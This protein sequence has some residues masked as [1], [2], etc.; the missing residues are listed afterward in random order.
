M[1]RFRIALAKPAIFLVV[2]QGRRCQRRSNRMNMHMHKY[3]LR[4]NFSICCSLPF[5]PLLSNVHL[6]DSFCSTFSRVSHRTY[7]S[8]TLLYLVG[9]LLA[10][11]RRLHMGLGKSGHDSYCRQCTVLYSN[12][13]EYYSF[14]LRYLPVDPTASECIL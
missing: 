7:I 14:L 9:K 6:W 5:C 12:N 4:E 3:I 10:R 1:V 13:L 11:K 8:I 2:E